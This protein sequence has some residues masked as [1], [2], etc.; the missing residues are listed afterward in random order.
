MTKLGYL[1]GAFVTTA[2][3]VTP[4]SAASMVEYALS[5]ARWFH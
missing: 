5:A 3:V 4:A 1:V 2:F